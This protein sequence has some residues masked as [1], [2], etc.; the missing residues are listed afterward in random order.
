MYLIMTSSSVGQWGMRMSSGCSLGIV[1]ESNAS[2]LYFS[3]SNTLILKL[4]A[5]FLHMR[6]QLGMWE[7][8]LEAVFL[9]FKSTKKD[10]TKNEKV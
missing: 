3:P 2:D 10:E 4:F 9:T 1:S 5:M 7:L 8:P 6:F